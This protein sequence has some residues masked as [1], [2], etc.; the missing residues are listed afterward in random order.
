MCII[1]ASSAFISRYWKDIRSQL[2]NTILGATIFISTAI[3]MVLCVD[4][5]YH[6]VQ[7]PVNPISVIM[8]QGLVRDTPNSSWWTIPKLSAVFCTLSISVALASYYARSRG[9]NRTAST[10]SIPVGDNTANKGVLGEQIP[11]LWW[12]PYE[13]RN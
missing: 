7:H 1:T 3:L 11:E 2:A 9:G 6:S 12:L 4:S 13:E 10:R 8:S 5:I